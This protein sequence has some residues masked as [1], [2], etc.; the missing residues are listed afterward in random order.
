M[1]ISGKRVLPIILSI[2]LSI[3]LPSTAIA[4][5]VYRRSGRTPR[6]PVS[7]STLNSRKSEAVFVK[8]K[9]EKLSQELNKIV[10]QHETAA[11]R[12]QF[13]DYA[14][15]QNQAKLEVA[16]QEL[17]KNQEILNKRVDAIY[18][19]GRLSF[20]NVLFGTEN[21]REFIQRYDLLKKVG[22]Q[23]QQVLEAVKRNKA[24]IE[25]R[26]QELVTGKLEAKYLVKRLKTQRVRI[27]GN[28]SKQKIFLAGMEAEVAK[29]RQAERRLRVAVSRESVTSRG[30]RTG[31]FV[32][33]VA[34][35]HSYS[36]SFGDP[37][38]GGRL[39]QGVDIFASSGTPTVASTS[40]SVNATW[41][42]GGGKT[43]YLSGDDGTTYVYMH[44]D[45]YAVTGGRVSAGETIGYVGDSGNARGSSPHLHFEVRPGGGRALDPYPI[46]RSAE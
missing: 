24:E 7:S 22:Q 20:S 46:L 26:Q 17:Q 11:N 6:Q 44:L 27:E 45:G 30:L 14:L 36:T 33:P 25:K 8:N 15:R 18:R 23:D 35:S 32:F 41:T 16:E 12:L 34:G 28:L 31:G 39:H 1:E 19:Y 29:L 43:I 9:I 42:N 4:A 13:I 38:P 2:V 10:R 21:Y 3:T 5:R 40:G 37:R